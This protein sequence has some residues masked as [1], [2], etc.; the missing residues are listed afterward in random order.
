MTTTQETKTYEVADLAAFQ[1]RM[2]RPSGVGD[3]A[4]G[5]LW[6]L[7]GAAS[8]D[9]RNWERKAA[10]VKGS[11]FNSRMTREEHER[12]ARCYT[13]IADKLHTLLRSIEAQS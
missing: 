10:A 6:A 2:N 9:A 8:R 4:I 3:L 11:T 12:Q 7:I 13:E 1:A 5:D